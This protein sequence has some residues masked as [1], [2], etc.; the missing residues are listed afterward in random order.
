MFLVFL[1]HFQQ[2]NL[3]LFELI[4]LLRFIS[5]SSKSFFVTKCACVNLAVNI[6]V[7]N[8]LNSEVVIYLP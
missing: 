3:F 8:L 6:S 4:F 1:V 5:L 2:V 7:V